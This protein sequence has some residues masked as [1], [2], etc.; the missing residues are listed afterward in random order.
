MII[1]KQGC[2]LPAHL[3]CQVC[4][5]NCATTLQPPV[6]PAQGK[7]FS[8]SVQHGTLLQKDLAFQNIASTSSHI[9]ASVSLPD[10]PLVL[11][12]T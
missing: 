4:E 8:I 2:Y 11:A 3:H 1:N 9:L 6:A 12:A 5:G 7:P 10:T